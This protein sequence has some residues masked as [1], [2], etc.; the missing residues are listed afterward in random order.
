MSYLLN[1]GS[2]GR[3]KTLCRPKNIK[4]NVIITYTIFSDRCFAVQWCGPKRYRP[5]ACTVQELPNVIDAIV[6]SHTHYDHLDYNS[7]FSLH[8]R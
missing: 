5:P 6:I 8:D 2:R 4:N 7:V 1:I 3:H